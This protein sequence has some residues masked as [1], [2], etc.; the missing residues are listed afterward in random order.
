M[1]KA[2]YGELGIVRST[3]AMFGAFA[4]LSLGLTATKHVAEFRLTDPLRAGRILALSGVV[5]FG[6][7][8]IV[9][10]AC[11]AL[12]PWLAAHTLAAPSWRACCGSAA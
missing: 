8:A 7:G 1:G 5:A 3:V 10:I 6:S 2:I 4:G 12:A 11:F 9:A